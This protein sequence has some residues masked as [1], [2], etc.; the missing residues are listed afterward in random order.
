MQP[1]NACY[2]QN[3]SVAA[4]YYLPSYVCN[5]DKDEDIDDSDLAEIGVSARY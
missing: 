2:P 5:D 3:D 4:A 1:D